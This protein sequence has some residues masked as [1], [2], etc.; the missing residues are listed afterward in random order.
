MISL[1]RVDRLG[2][3]MNDP[4]VMKVD[5]GIGCQEEGHCKVQEG[6][7]RTGTAIQL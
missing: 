7:G 6:S 2:T 5:E 1:S 3:E 4:K